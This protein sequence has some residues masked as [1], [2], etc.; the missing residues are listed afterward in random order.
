MHLELVPSSG[1]A[2]VVWRGANRKITLPTVTNKCAF[3]A[4]ISPQKLCDI[5]KFLYWRENLKSVGILVLKLVLFIKLICLDVSR[6]AHSNMYLPI[7]D[8]Q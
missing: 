3:S 5:S 7:Y 1:V 8:L 6:S 2:G 4:S